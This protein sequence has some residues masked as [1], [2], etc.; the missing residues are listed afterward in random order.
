ML[1]SIVVAAGVSFVVGAA[2]L[3]FGRGAD[4]A[5]AD[6]GATPPDSVELAEAVEEDVEH[7]GEA[8]ASS[9]T[10]ASTPNNGAVAAPARPVISGKDVK[11]SWSPAT[12]AWA[13]A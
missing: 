5:D 2:L 6:P 7:A 8:P 10:P 11:A 3:K 4:A 12:R 1:L 9:A 13:A